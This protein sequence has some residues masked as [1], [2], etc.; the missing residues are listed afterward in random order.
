MEEYV[1]VGE[2]FTNVEWLI[3]KKKMRKYYVPYFNRV[4]QTD[5]KLNTSRGQM[6]FL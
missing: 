6:S 5:S 2:C 3:M 4:K 1:N